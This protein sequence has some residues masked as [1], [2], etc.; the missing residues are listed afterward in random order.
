[1]NGEKPQKLDLQTVLDEFDKFTEHYQ[2]HRKTAKLYRHMVLSFFRFLQDKK[3]DFER[4]IS[5]TVFNEFFKSRGNIKLRTKKIY[6]WLANE[7]FMWLMNKNLIADNPMDNIRNLFVKTRGIK[8]K[9]LPTVL[10]QSEMKT[11]TEHLFRSVNSYTEQRKQ[12]ALL[13]G[14][15]CGL[16]NEE[17]RLLK[18]EHLHLN[19]EMPYL[20]V[21]G[22]YAKERVVPLP[23]RLADKIADFIDDKA[24]F[25]CA[26][27]DYLLGKRTDGTPY[28]EQGLI[29]LARTE[30][31]RLGIIKRKMTPHV[32][33]HTYCTALFTRGVPAYRV[34]LLMGHSN[35]ATTQ[36]YEHVG[37][38]MDKEH[39]LA[40]L[41]DLPDLGG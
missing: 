23:Q 13:L 33:R 35:L 37:M 14:L 30:L 15:L 39:L 4:D 41:A 21:T 24:S 6:V 8:E 1:M 18:P 34:M 9:P 16:R 2:Y 38:F 11:L 3:L 40:D 36:I 17:I 7:I 22:K 32:L 20:N 10:T 25:K 5:N 12:I 31:S 28:T 27:S 26:G 19:E 29:Y